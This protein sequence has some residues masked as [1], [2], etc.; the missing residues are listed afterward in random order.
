MWFLFTL[1]VVILLFLFPKPMSVVLGV[2]AVVGAVVGLVYHFQS[3]DMAA[4]REAV[5]LSVRYDPAQCPEHKPLLVSVSN[6]SDFVVQRLDWVF[7]ARRPG[8]R[9][10]LTGDWLRPQSM[11]EEIPAGS[12]WTG[13]FAAP[14]PSEHT[15]QRQ[16][17]H[18][19]KLEIGIRNSEITFAE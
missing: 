7:S 10:E 8:Y 5:E 12:V 9:S 3:R 6:Q 18:P 15:F 14:D 13:C 1:L 17:D 2:A 11:A 19:S 16:T 4:Q